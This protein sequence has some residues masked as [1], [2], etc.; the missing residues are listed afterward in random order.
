MT[1]NIKQNI[2]F[3][4]NQQKF[5]QC[6]SFYQI[7]VINLVFPSNS[8]FHCSGVK[9]PAVYVIVCFL[10]KFSTYLLYEYFKSHF[11]RNLQYR[12]RWVHKQKHNSWPNINL[13]MHIINLTVL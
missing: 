10:T 4:S 2:F 9:P 3:R 12:R 11:Y 6:T 7:S 5:L 1:L 13:I 8:M